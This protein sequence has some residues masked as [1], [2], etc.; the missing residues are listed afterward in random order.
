[1]NQETDFFE[2]AAKVGLTK[3]LGGVAATEALVELCHIG[4]GK[5]VLD[6]GCGVGVTPCY[7]AKK[8]DCR[9]VGVD[10]SER[11]IERSEQRMR[12]TKLT[13]LLEF[14]V[15]DALDLPFENN[16][17]DAVITESVTSF[18]EDKQ[19]AIGEYVR[20]TKSGG[21]VGL[22]ESIWRKVPPP[23]EVIAWASQDIG[24]NVQPLTSDAW[25]DLLQSAGL[26]KITSRT[27]VVNSR[28]EAR[29]ILKR[30]GLGGMMSVLWRMRLLYA[31]STAYRN[32][33]KRIRQMGL[34]PDN[35]DQ[36]FGYGIFVGQK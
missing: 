15:A 9:V 20:V 31:R 24:A 21:Y 19:K 10:I 22:N 6:V 5:K 4:R 11:M 33:V 34:A 26:K 27:F 35:L 29:G 32:F 3:H 36:Y 1:M 8:Y 13:D 30:Y 12:K 23:P 18:P 2:F 17:F 16:F 25:V 28:G 14:R 7:I